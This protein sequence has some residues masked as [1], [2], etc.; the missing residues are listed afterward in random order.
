VSWEIRQ[1]DAAQRLQEMPTGSVQCC[2]TSPPYY[3]LRDY[4]TGEWQGGNPECD[5]STGRGSNT[6]QTKFAAADGYP[7]SAPHRGGGGNVCTTCGARRVD[8]QVGLEDTPTAYVERLVEIFREVRR[9]LRDDGT[10]WLN[11]GDTYNAYNGNA[12]QGGPVGLTQSIE[13][14]KLPKGHGL[15]VKTLKAKDLIGIPWMVAFALRSDGWYLR[16]DIIWAK[17]NPMP[18]SVID[19]PTS[20]H[21]HL[22]LLAKSPRYF[23]DADAVREP[24]AAGTAKRYEAPFVD[25][26]AQAASGGWRGEFGGKDGAQL[27]P[28]GRNKRNVWEIVTQPYPDAHFATFPPKLVEPCVLAGSSPKACGECGAPWRRLTETEYR[29]HENWFGDKQ[30]A[31]HSRGEAG[32]SYRE[33]VGTQT[34]GWETTCGH[35]DD[36]GRCVVLDPFA[37]SGTVGVVCEWFDRDFVGIELNPDYC[38][39]AKRRIMRRERPSQAPDVSAEQMALEL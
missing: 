30:A 4:G 15:T 5:H 10:V 19:R 32:T 33:P 25:R 1:G 7:A 13:R 21:E 16:S 28:N 23:Y 24:H 14:P 6:K 8:S 27:N 29:V 9:V 3:G 12:G 39:M 20:A 34:V 31:R 22:F 38:E 26:Y 18:E 17:P 36:A 35:Q 2:V 11:L 37:G